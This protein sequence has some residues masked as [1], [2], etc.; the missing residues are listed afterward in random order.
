M[1]Y[2]QW[3]PVLESKELKKGKPLGIMRLGERLAFYRKYSGEVVCMYDKCTHRG[4]S[5]S[6]GEVVNDHLQ[7]PFHGLEFDDKGLCVKIPANGSLYEI[8]ERYNNQHFK[9]KEVHD[10]IWIFYGD[11]EK[12][13][14]EIPYFDEVTEF[15]SYSTLVD[16]WNVHYSRVIENQLDVVHL[17][18][19]HRTTI[20]RGNKTLVNGP[21]AEWIDDELNIWVFNAVDQG[22]VPLKEKDLKANY[23]P[24]LKFRFPNIW[25]NLISDKIKLVIA[26]VPI[27]DENTKLY[28]R[29]Y[30]KISKVPIFKEL[31]T[32]SGKAGSLVIERQDKR[33]VETQ[34]PKRSY[35][36]VSENLLPGDR[37]IVMYRVKRDE[38]IKK[39]S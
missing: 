19:V 27:D 22:Q 13:T 12:A 5:L 8:P 23:P 37:P 29:Y 7:C 38:L 31:I 35:L 18:F 25:L 28:M 33:V 17:P 32:L 30:Q 34:L 4:A 21:V 2:N 14:E 36:G 20:G 15:Y 24:Q 3:Y 26:F 1:I 9:T 11:A 6:H 10:F 39:N 16:H